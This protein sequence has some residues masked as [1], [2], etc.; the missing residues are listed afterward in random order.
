MDIGESQGA[1]A[2]ALAQK[3][4]ALEE[5]ENALE[6][7]RAAAMRARGREASRIKEQSDKQLVEI[8]KAGENQ[9]EM[10]KKLNSDRIKSLNENTQKNFIDLSERTAAEIRRLD[11]DALKAIENHRL[12]TMEKVTSATSHSEDPFYR[13]KSLNPVLAEA[14]REFTVKVM[15]PEHEAR[16]VFVTGEGQ[17]LKLSL[18]RRYQEQVKSA[19][20]NQNTK[21]SSFQTVVETLALPGAINARGIS[22]EYADGTLTIRIPKILGLP[23]DFGKA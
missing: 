4:T 13:L 3:R 20:T 7:Q 18:A 5:E 9:A 2:R 22:R 23:E 15:L 12:G 21:T 6:V 10:V 14:E 16:N 8:S 11:S 19:E 17:S 1:A